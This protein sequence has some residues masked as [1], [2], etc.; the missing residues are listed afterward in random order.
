MCSDDHDT[1]AITSLVYFPFIGVN[2]RVSLLNFGYS[3]LKRTI[4]LLLVKKFGNK[5]VF[6][7]LLFLEAELE[8]DPFVNQDSIFEKNINYNVKNVNTAIKSNKQRE[9]VIFNN[10]DSHNDLGDNSVAIPERN[11]DAKVEN[12]Q[13]I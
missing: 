9:Q 8:D 11:I 2:E 1:K 5:T 10:R 3:F 6:H 13:I 12:G 7:Q 4:F